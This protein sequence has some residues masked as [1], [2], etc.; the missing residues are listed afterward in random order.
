M[1]T[2]LGICIVGFAIVALVALTGSDALVVTGVLVT[3][4]GMVVGLTAAVQGGGWRA[5]KP[6]RCLRGPWQWALPY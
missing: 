5:A 2:G 6:G 3:A 4:G 1:F